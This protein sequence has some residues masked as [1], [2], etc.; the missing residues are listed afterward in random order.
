MKKNKIIL[1]FL[2]FICAFFIGSITSALYAMSGGEAHNLSEVISD[3]SGKYYKNTSILDIDTDDVKYLND[4]DFSKFEVLES[5]FI[6]NADLKEINSIKIGKKIKFLSITNT[7]LDYNI[8]DE[9]EYDIISVS[10]SYN[11]GN[12]YRGTRFKFINSENQISTNYDQKID[13]I[14]KEIYLKSDKTINGIIKDVT[15][16]V[17]DNIEYDSNNQYTHLDKAE[18]VIEKKMGVCEHYAWFESQLLNKLGIFTL[19]VDGYNRDVNNDAHAWN[20]VYINGEWYSIDP[21]WIDTEIGRNSLIQNNSYIYYMKPITDQKFNS[22]HV[23]KFNVYDYIPINKRK[24]DMSI[25]EKYNL[26]KTGETEDKIEETENKAEETENKI[27]KTE[28]KAEETENKTEETENKTEETENKTEKIENKTEETENKVEKKEN[29]RE[30]FD[31]NEKK[32]INNEKFVES[33]K[34]QNMVDTDNSQKYDG[35]FTWIIVVAIPIVGIS[36]IFIYKKYL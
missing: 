23:L 36:G 3:K 31:D 19:N 33:S 5:V 2:L 30:E 15:L 21:T 1:M 7:I 20:I 4:V 14:A 29:K 34:N 18:S 13:E 35:L 6:R 9:N 25:I 10:Q 24:N 11:I 8:F 32:Q 26:N 27:E 17:I 22:R 28:N 12:I 16:Y